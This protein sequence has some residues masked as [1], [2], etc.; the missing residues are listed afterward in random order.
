M[1]GNSAVQAYAFVSHFPYRHQQCWWK[2]T[3]SCNLCLFVGSYYLTESLIRRMIE[4]LGLEGTPRIIKF[5]APCRR[6]P[7][8]VLDQIAQGSIKCGIF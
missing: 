3:V 1:S 2:T 7:A 6:L 4:W 8:Q 5:Q